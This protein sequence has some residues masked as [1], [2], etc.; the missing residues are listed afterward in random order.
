MIPIPRPSLSLSPQLS[1]RVGEKIFNGQREKREITYIKFTTAE[2][3][4]RSA[5]K[6]GEKL[7]AKLEEGGGTRWAH[8]QMGD[9][10][11]FSRREGDWMTIA[12][13][14]EEG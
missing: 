6:S 3:L 2:G 11:L 9:L 12:R 5:D 8:T 14:Q 13:E 1:G 4:A 7:G 10:F